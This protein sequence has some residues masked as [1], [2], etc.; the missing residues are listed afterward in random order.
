MPN[1]GI[2]YGCPD[3]D[4]VY[5][6]RM[7]T[8]SLA[9]SP[10]PGLRACSGTDGFELSL[11]IGA[12]KN[13]LPVWSCSGRLLR[14]QDPASPR[15]FIG[16]H[17][18]GPGTRDPAIGVPAL[19]L[20]EAGTPE[21][22]GEQ[23]ALHEALCDLRGPALP[24]LHDQGRGQGTSPRL[25]HRQ[26]SGEAVHGGTAASDWKA[27]TQGDRR[28]RGLYPKRPDVSDR[29]ERLGPGPAHLVRREGP[30]RGQHG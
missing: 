11:S 15:P 26:G 6:S 14:S 8:A 23:S 30:V 24:V 3:K 18:S 20:G 10:L 13:G 7:H 27:R 17:P 2:L 16:R 28:R 12:Q 4:D 9:S 21:L 1:R 22:P 25:A 29:G 19:W 5:I